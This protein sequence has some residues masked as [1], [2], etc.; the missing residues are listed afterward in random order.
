MESDINKNIQS[1]WIGGQLS[2]VEQLCIQSFIDHGHNFHLYAYEEITNAPKGTIILDARSI[3]GEDAIFKYKSGWGAG[4]VSGFADLFR[5]L[6]VQKNGGWWVDMDIICLKKF[7]F[8]A[9]TVF[10]SSFEGEYDQLVNN[11]VFKAPKDS[12]FIQYCLDQ[13]ALIDLKT[14][15]FGMAGPF[16]FQKVVKELQLEKYVLPYSYFNPIAWKNVS[17][18][19]LG[20]MNKADRIKEFIRPV[21]K[22]NTMPGRKIGPHSYT[23]HFWNEIWNTGK[24][25]KNGVYDSNSLFEKL[26]RKHGIK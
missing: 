3:I 11:C 26:K 6:M 15:P 21:L 20:K 24:L 14:M 13:I 25:D 18:L 2:K 5:L 9:D 1:L 4:S 10:C 17:T 19:I 7:D 16:L 22:P 23:V 12:E 8:E